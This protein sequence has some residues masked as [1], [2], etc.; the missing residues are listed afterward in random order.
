[1]THFLVLSQ[2]RVL[3]Q[4]FKLYDMNS[5]QRALWYYKDVMNG[6]PKVTLCKFLQMLYRLIPQYIPWVGSEH[7]IEPLTYRFMNYQ[8]R[9]PRCGVV[10]FCEG[11]ILV[12][13][14]VY[15]RNL[16]FPMGKQ[17]R[18]EPSYECAMRECFEE[19]GIRVFLH[20]DSEK[21]IFRSN[22][23]APR[24]LYIVHLQCKIDMIQIIPQTTYEVSTYRWVD[25]QWFDIH[26]PFRA[27]NKNGWVSFIHYLRHRIRLP[28]LLTYVSTEPS[29]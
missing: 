22:G 21:V 14:S 20:Q 15:G 29:G 19:T 3:C 1:M 23:H 7:R 11:K 24:H 13:K 2:A 5:V 18:N 17:Y 16:M 6:N 25:H 12:L 4:K 27:F 9:L 28:P 26:K 10:L 8:N